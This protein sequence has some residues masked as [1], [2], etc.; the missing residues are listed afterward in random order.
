MF[1]GCENFEAEGLNKW[2][3]NKV[4]DKE[5]MFYGCIA[6]KNKPSWYK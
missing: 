2:N 5:M 6:L 1:N 4:K 3:V